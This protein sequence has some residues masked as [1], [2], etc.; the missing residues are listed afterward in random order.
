MG[1]STAPS[2]RAQ[3]ANHVVI[4]EFEL[5]PAG[6]DYGMTEFVE[7]YNPTSTSVNIGGWKVTTTQSINRT[8]SVC[9]GP[10]YGGSELMIITLTIPPGTSIPAN[11]YY[12]V[13]DP[14]MPWLADENN[15]I[16][17]RDAAGNE[18]DRTPVKSDLYD[19][20][21]SWQRN[22]DG[23]ADWVFQTSTRNASIP[24]FPSASI[25]LAVTLLTVLIM[26]GK[27]TKLIT[28]KV[29]KSTIN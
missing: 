9:H 21:R 1:I 5:N 15:S 10:G 26:L 25:I 6:V 23:G 3:I 27:Q 14:H 7:L 18:V 28:K 17:L 16:I 22:P 19:D 24:E 2:A 11:G 8:C 13:N 12:T 29:D 20:A 4:N